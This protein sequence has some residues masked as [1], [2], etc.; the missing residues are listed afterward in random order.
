MN[1]HVQLSGRKEF[2]NN[3]V[4]EAVVMGRGLLLY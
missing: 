1:S 3:S 4:P 2:V